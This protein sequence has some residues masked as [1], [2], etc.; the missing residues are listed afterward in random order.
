MKTKYFFIAIIMSSIFLICCNTKQN[1]SLLKKENQVG[2]IMGNDFRSKSMIKFMNAYI[3]NN[4][5]SVANLF[6][7][8]AKIMINDI[9]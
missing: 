4:L 1:S 9:N 7:P 5:N 6:L 8:D 3:D 2:I